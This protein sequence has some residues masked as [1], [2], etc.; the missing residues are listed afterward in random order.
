MRILRVRGA[1]LLSFRACRMF[2]TVVKCAFWT[3]LS[4]PFVILC[5]ADVENWCFCGGGGGGGGCVLVVFL[6]CVVVWWRFCGA[7]VFW[8]FFGWCSWCFCGGVLWWCFGGVFVVVFLWWCIGGSVFVV[9]LRWCS[10]G[11]GFVVVFL[12]WRSACVFVVF[13]RWCF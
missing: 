10:G 11:G 8:C 1:T 3:S 4:D 2:K 7:V 5:V 9:F 12:R 6:W 13:L